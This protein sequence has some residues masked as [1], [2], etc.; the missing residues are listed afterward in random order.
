[1]S[2]IGKMPVKV[3]TGVNVTIA[4]DNKVTVKGP[5]GELVSSF[6]TNMI[7]VLENGELTVS[8]PNDE[9]Q[10]RALHGL[11][12]SLIANMV[13]GVT[14]GF[15]KDL[16]LEGTGYRVQKQGNKIVLQVGYSHPV[17][18][19]EENGIVFE[20]PAQNKI[21]VKGIDKQ[22]VGEVAATIRGIRPPEPYHGKGIR[23]EGERI[24]LKAGKTGAKK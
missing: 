16:S 3:P 19:V 18:V 14:D 9:K 22:R 17:E 8:R 12:R 15:Q 24:K 6:S 23:Y 7:I 5:K 20:C 21:S 13:K 2:R 11:T 10:N 4:P 1:M